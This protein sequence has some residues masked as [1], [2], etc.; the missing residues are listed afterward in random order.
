MVDRVDLGDTGIRVSLKLPIPATASPLAATADELSIARFLPTTIR[1]RG[2]EM[3]LLVE[4][5]RAPAPR[6][7]AAHLKAVARA[8]L[9]SRARPWYEDLLVV[10]R[11][12]WW[13]LLN[14]SA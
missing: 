5:N 9:W 11:S 8:R 4:G 12:Q 3:R 1:R 13:S 2:V 14:A 7:D 10:E 6:A